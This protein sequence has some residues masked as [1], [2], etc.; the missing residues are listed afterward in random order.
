VPLRVRALS[1]LSALADGARRSHDNAKFASGGGD[2]TVF[3]WDVATGQTTRRLPGHIGKVN[4]VEFNDDATVLASG[5]Y[6]MLGAIASTHPTQAL[7]TRPSACGISSV[8]ALP[9]ARL[10]RH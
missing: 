8:C 1:S 9:S 3:V 10:Q 4:A 7:T 2:R 6:E 5:M